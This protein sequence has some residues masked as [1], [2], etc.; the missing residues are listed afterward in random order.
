MTARPPLTSAESASMLAE[1]KR[2]QADFDQWAAA[3]IARRTR[4]ADEYRAAY[5]AGWRAG[6]TRSD[7]GDRKRAAAPFVADAYQL[8]AW[9]CGYGEGRSMRTMTP[10][11]LDAQER[12]RDALFAKIRE[13]TSRE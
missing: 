10:A 13:N 11:E 6:R 9:A 4:V 12:R 1:S 7:D 3:M 8:V 5:R 2:R